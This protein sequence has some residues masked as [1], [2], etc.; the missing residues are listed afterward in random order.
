MEPRAST[1]PLIILGRF[2]LMLFTIEVIPYTI[3]VN[4]LG[5]LL[6]TALSI[7]VNTCAIVSI[8]FGKFY[9]MPSTTPSIIDIPTSRILGI[10]SLTAYNAFSMPSVIA[11][12]PS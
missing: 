4:T 8:I 6:T 5:K 3:A 1:I 11:F 12:A 7:L 9:V 2:S 10:R